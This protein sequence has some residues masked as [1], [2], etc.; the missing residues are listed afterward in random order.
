MVAKPDRFA[1]PLS[2]LGF[3]QDQATLWK[4]AAGPDRIPKES[5][6]GSITD[7]EGG[8]GQSIFGGSF[9]PTLGPVQPCLI[10]SN[11]TIGDS[12]KKSST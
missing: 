3:R 11:P 9:V 7:C 6:T 12:P 4:W 1:F 8:A 10:V 5:R 2:A